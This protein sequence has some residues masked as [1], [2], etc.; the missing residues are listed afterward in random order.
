MKYEVNAKNS[1]NIFRAVFCILLDFVFLCFLCV[2][3]VEKIV[4]GVKNKFISRQRENNQIKY[5][6]NILK[7]NFYYFKNTFCYLGKIQF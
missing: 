7:R 2:Y 6:K 3:V 4:F 5:K 1:A